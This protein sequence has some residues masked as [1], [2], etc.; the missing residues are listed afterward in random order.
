[1]GTSGGS[2]AHF[3]MRKGQRAWKRQP[4]GGAVMF[5]TVPSMAASRGRRAVEA[6]KRAEEA[7]GVGVLGK[8][9]E[10]LDRRALDH[11]P[12]VHDEHLVADLRDDAEVVRDQNDRGAALLAQAGASDRGSA[13]GW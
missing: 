1:M 6:R 10:L 3:G 13:P 8:A 2:S 5:G 4:S 12:G 11:L 7:D 9:E